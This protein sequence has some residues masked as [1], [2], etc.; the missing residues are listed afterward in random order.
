MF[1]PFIRDGY[2]GRLPTRLC[3]V[4]FCKLNAVTSL[5]SREEPRVGDYTVCINCHSVLRYGLGMDLIKSSLLEVPT[6]LRAAFAKVIRCMEA[7][8]PLPRKKNKSS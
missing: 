2:T 5:T 7:M 6:H 1:N 4:C 3:P 8:P